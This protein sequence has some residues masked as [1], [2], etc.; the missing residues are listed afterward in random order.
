[1]SIIL[2]DFAEIPSF[3]VLCY[4]EKQLLLAKKVQH[5]P[6]LLFID[7]TGS[8]TRK[9]N[10]KVT[11]FYAGVLS[12]AFPKKPCLP[13]FELLSNDQSGNSLA[14]ML[15]SWKLEA[16]KNQ[17]KPDIICV[18]FSWALIY[19][20]FKSFNGINIEEG[21]NRQWEFLNGNTCDSFT[22]VRLCVSHFIKSSI[23]RLYKMNISKRVI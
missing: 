23:N 15:Y 4:T 18:D 20:V 19:A 7:A 16:E 13:V 5:K 10:N 12:T 8:L 21:L 11:F 22:V 3:K 6:N 1:M 9:W 17:L 2:Q 14:Q